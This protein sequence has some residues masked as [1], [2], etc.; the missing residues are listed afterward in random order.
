[1]KTFLLIFLF[2][3]PAALASQTTE[4]LQLIYYPGSWVRPDTCFQELNRKYGFIAAETTC[5]GPGTR[6]RRHNERAEKKLQERNGINWK[7]A[8]NEELQH[9][10]ALLQEQ[11]GSK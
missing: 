8:Y 2:A 6:Q 5:T 9:C 3:L 4:K 11:Q 1:M 7:K 10:D